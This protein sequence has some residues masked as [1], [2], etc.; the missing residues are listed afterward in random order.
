[1]L[2]LCEGLWGRRRAERGRPAHEHGRPENPDGSRVS[3]RRAAWRQTLDGGWAAAR[4]GG[5]GGTAGACILLRGRKCDLRLVKYLRLEFLYF[6]FSGRSRAWIR[7]PRHRRGKLACRG[8]SVCPGPGAAAPAGQ[9]FPRRAHAPPTCEHTVTLGASAAASSGPRRKTQQ[10]MQAHSHDLPTSDTPASAGAAPKCTECPQP[11]AAHRTRLGG[12]RDGGVGRGHELPSCQVSKFRT[13]G[14]SD[15]ATAG[16]AAVHAG[17][18]RR[19]RV[20][21][22]TLTWL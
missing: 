16:N 21:A 12:G 9:V 6:R 7:G 22:G 15:A 5:W 1:M 14:Y 8:E 4:P 13:P 11:H 3:R 19:G 2:E 10:R 17:S 18:P 20:A